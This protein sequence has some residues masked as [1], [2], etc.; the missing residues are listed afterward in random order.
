M[1]D[2]IRRSK[3]LRAGIGKFPNS[4]NERKQMSTKTMKQ[5]VALIAVSALTAGVL[6]AVATAPVASANGLVTNT[7]SSV[8]LLAG[9]GNTLTAGTTT[10]HTATILSSGILNLTYGGGSTIVVS[11]GARITSASTTA[12]IAADQLSAANVTAVGITPTGAV[13][14]TFTVSGYSESTLAAITT[15]DSV[16]TVTIAASSVAGVPAVSEST[17]RWA[18][19]NS[20]VPTSAESVANAADDYE[21]NNLFVY[22][23]LEDAYG[24]NVTSGSGALVVTASAGAT[25]GN[26]AASGA[27]SGSTN[28][29]I[30]STD[31]ST[32]WA[33]VKSATAGVPWAG[34]VTVAYNGVTLATLTGAITGAPAKL[35]L[36]ASKA[37]KTASANAAGFTYK[38]T[39]SAGNGLA[40]TSSNLSLDKSSSSSVVATASGGTTNAAFGNSIGDYVGTGDFTCALAGTSNVS[41]SL[42]IPGTGTVVKSDPIALRCAGAAAS[43]T[44]GFD[45]ASYIQGEIA[46][47]TVTFRDLAGNLANSYD[48][49]DAV[50][51]SLTNASISAPMLALV[52]LVN[53]TQAAATT[54]KP[55]LSG[56]RTYTFTV[57]TAGGLTA[58]SYNAVVDFPTVNAVVSTTKAQTVAY[59][60]TTGGSSV[61]N[62]DVLK[63]IVALIASINKQIQALQKLILKR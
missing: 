38:V 5:R 33:V 27:T 46:T 30:L 25:I 57:G 17:F 36:T 45:K 39:D 52:G 31:P 29:G 9:G 6:S 1:G 22:I 53:P 7:V 55:G 48:A 26:P 20:N 2:G 40:F 63:S 49:V 28:V 61:T 35:T 23:D 43:Y 13:G 16:M 44:A 62:E 58:G 21:S 60:L 4:T 47:L 14:T 34:T 51:S 32:V 54:I 18:S 24:A 42:V 19:S 59:K 8:G 56:T 3:D 11:A 41:M 15:P 37:G 50:T 12:S 10:T